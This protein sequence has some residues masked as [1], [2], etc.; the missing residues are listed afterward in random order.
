[1]SNLDS[2][3]SHS[4]QRSQPA[5]PPP[6]YTI[7]TANLADLSVLVDILITSF[8]PPNRFNRWLYPLMRVGINEDLKLRLKAGSTRYYCLAAISSQ[9]Q[10]AGTV[11]VSLRSP[12]PFSP[13]RA[14]ISNLAVEKLHRRQ[15]VAQQ[16]L[17]TCET[18]AQTWGQQQLYLHVATDNSSAQRLYQKLGYRSADPLIEQLTQQ[19]GLPSQK[20]LQ[21]KD[22]QLS[23]TNVVNS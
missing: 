2:G 1:M 12:L 23:Q 19:L 7:R 15:G 18:M 21:V 22:L 13:Q 11:E 5:L 9:G 20:Q 17:Q 3:S 8:Y 6:T 14:Y 16:L 10:L 4:G